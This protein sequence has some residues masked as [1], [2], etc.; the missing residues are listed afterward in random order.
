MK[1]RIDS[2]PTHKAHYLVVA[3]DKGQGYDPGTSE[4]IIAKFPSRKQAVTARDALE[5]FG[6]HRYVQGINFERHWNAVQ[7]SAP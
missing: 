4:T 6:D 5:W 1:L 2:Y 3:H 7:G